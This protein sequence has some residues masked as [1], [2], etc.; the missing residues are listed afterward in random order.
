MKP[1]LKT[2]PKVSAE[3]E[4]DFD[5]GI[6]GER[7]ALIPAG[8]YDVGFVR[9]V[10]PF[11]CFNHQRTLLWFRVTTAGEHHGVELYMACR[12]SPREGKKSLAPSSK[13]VR[14]CALA[15]GRWPSRTDRL[16]T[17]AFKGKAFAARVETVTHDPKKQ[18]LSTE[19]QYSIIR[20]LTKK[21]AG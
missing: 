15:L 12:T 13:L 19:A 21:I 9:A 11:W 14:A 6:A 2:V 8:D 7:G 16:S 17:T 18:P 10:K 3:E 4:A 5:F 1:K 20:S